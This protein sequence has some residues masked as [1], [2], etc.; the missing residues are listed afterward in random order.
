MSRCLSDK[1]LMRVM[2]EL[3]STAEQA[4]VAACATCAARR[5]RISGEVERVCQVL[6]TTP[7]PARRAVRKPQRSMVAAAGLAALALAALVWIEVAVWKTMQPTEDL[8]STQVEAAL[9]DVTAATFSVDGEPAR[10]LG[11]SSTSIDF[12]PDDVAGTGCEEPARLDEAE[13]ADTLQSLEEPQ[14]EWTDMDSTERTAFDA[15]SA[16]QGG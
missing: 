13:C 7:E 3:G 10:L 6:L 11:E 4:H 9:A 15:E 5:R 8:A 1:A 12:D 14:E 2:A 16:D